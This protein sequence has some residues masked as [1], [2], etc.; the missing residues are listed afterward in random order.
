MVEEERIGGW[1]LWRGGQCGGLSSREQ[2]EVA[3]A[4]GDPRFPSQ[5]IFGP[6]PGA[7]YQQD[8]VCKRRSAGHG[9]HL[10]FAEF[11]S[12]TKTCTCDHQLSL[13]SPCA[14]GEQRFA[15]DQDRGGH[16]ESW[17]PPGATWSSTLCGR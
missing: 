17:V 15:Q 9:R 14:P 5:Y 8:G 10:V 11:Y 3:A 16:L 4:L 6:Q 7:R 2:A 12:F 13:R 1:G